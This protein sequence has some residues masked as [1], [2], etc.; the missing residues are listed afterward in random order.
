MCNIGNLTYEHLT[1]LN[2]NQATLV[3]SQLSGDEEERDDPAVEPALD[4][5]NTAEL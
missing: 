5:P 1:Y 3:Q 2:T 4:L